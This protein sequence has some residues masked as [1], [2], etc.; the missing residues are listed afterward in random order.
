VIHCTVIL[1]VVLCDIV[2]MVCNMLLFFPNILSI[3]VQQVDPVLMLFIS[4]LR[5]SMCVSSFKM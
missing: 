4:T 1:T 3:V 2:E 5:I